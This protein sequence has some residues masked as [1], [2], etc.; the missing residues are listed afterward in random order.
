MRKKLIY[1]FSG[2][3]LLAIGLFAYHFYAANNAEKTLDET[4]QETISKSSINLTIDYSSIEVSPFSGDILFSNINIIH[5]QDIQRATAARFDLKYSDFLNFMIW[6]TESGLKQVE[7][8]VLKLEN[9]S[10][11]NRETFLEVKMDSLDIDYKG[12]L[13]NLIVLG[14]TRRPAQIQHDIYATGTTFSFYHP[15]AGIGQIRADSVQLDTHLGKSPNNS[16][17]LL[18]SVELSG[19]TWTPVS[20]FQEKYQFFIQGFGYQTDAI[21]LQRATLTYRYTLEDNL[22]SIKKMAVDSDLFIISLNGYLMLDEGQF[23]NSNLR[24]VEIRIHEMSPRFQTFL[25]QLE[26]LMGMQIPGGGNEMR[27]Q[28]NGPLSKPEFTFQP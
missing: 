4:I 1:F 3:L 22:F 12:N 10:Y 21:P 13:W 5:D 17:S 28:L 19:I 27:I 16:D 23:S 7:E 20:T 15:E 8:G 2:V 24:N 9:I 11:T 14:V 6:G 25:Q 26:K 18:N